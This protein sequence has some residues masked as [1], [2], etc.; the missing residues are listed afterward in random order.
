MDGQRRDGSGRFEHDTSASEARRAGSE[1]EED[2]QAELA[3]SEAAAIGGRAGDQDLA[4]ELRPLIEAGEGESEGFDEAERLLVEHASHG[5][6][7]SAHAVLH[8]QGRPEQDRP[9]EDAEPDHEHRSEDDE[10][11]IG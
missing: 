1:P 4:P 10:A 2:A 11:G 5:D 6:Q 9:E 8:H 3:G 7:Q